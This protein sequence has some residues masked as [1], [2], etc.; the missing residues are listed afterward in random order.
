MTSQRMNADGW[1]TLV[2]GM[3]AR[4]AQASDDQ[5]KMIVEYLTKTLG[6]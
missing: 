5:A 4:G 2:Q 6:R 3:V 1:N